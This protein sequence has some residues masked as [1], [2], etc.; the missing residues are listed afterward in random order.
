MRRLRD[1]GRVGDASSL[2][3]PGFACHGY[4]ADRYFTLSQ[5]MSKISILLQGEK[6]MKTLAFRDVMLAKAANREWL[7]KRLLRKQALLFL[8]KKKQKNSYDLWALAPSGPG[9]TIIRRFLLLFFKKE[10]LPSLS[11]E[12]VH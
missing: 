3:G 10:A 6:L 5:G 9:P 8:Q 7:V 1:A 11:R 2:C 4:R 12:P